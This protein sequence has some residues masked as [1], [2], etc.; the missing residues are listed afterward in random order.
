MSTQA[1]YTPD[2]WNILV[3][4]PV[5][6]SML[7]IKSDQSGGIT[8]HFGVVQETRD[9]RDAVQNVA[10]TAVAPLVKETANALLGEQSWKPLIERSSPESV[11]SSLSRVDTILANKASP[12]EVQAYKQYVYG[13]ATKTASATKE[14]SGVQTSD[15]EKVALQQI[16]SLL[17]LNG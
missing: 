4:A 15:K 7:V 6:A 11:T 3:H 2:E 13:I 10:D 9:A 14:S 12:D 8:G 16:A 1:D 5:Q 17:K